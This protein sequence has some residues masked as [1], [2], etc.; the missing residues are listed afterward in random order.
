MQAGLAKKAYTFRQIF[1]S[2]FYWAIISVELI[3]PDVNWT[4]ESTPRKVA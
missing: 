4:I 2:R 1:M 3:D